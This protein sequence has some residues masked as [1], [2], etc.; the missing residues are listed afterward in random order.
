MEEVTE[1]ISNASI[2]LKDNKA[3]IG[4]VLSG[5][6]NK[7]L[8]HLKTTSTALKASVPHFYT[9]IQSGKKTAENTLPTLVS[10]SSV[11]Y[12]STIR[13]FLAN[14]MALTSAIVGTSL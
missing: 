2:I 1:A 11:R 14:W 5:H 10:A 4:N 12:S 6:F 3:S 9:K 8:K 13:V 7:P